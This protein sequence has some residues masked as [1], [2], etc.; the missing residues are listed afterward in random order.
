MMKNV[1]IFFYI[2]MDQMTGR[3]ELVAACADHGILL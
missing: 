2:F 3:V 1:Y